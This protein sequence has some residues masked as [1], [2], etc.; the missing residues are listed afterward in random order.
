MTVKELIK[1]LE[2]LPNKDMP[3]GIYDNQD[4]LWFE[5]K[6]HNMSIRNI[7]GLEGNEGEDLEDPNDPEC[8]CIGQDKTEHLKVSKMNWIDWKIYD[9]YYYFRLN[10]GIKT[11]P[12]IHTPNGFDIYRQCIL[13]NDYGYDSDSHWTFV[14]TLLPWIQFCVVYT[15]TR[16]KIRD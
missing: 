14:G 11:H 1:Y 4:H 9:M 5:F 7:N 6:K 15:F 13:E 10:R 16:Q 3:I 12:N 8:L 2:A